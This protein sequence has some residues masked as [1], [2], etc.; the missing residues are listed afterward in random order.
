MK[1]IRASKKI[2]DYNINE[3]GIPDILYCKI[4]Y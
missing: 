1:N 4:N 2:E 3:L